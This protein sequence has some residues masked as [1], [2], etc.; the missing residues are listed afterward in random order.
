MQCQHREYQAKHWLQNKKGRLAPVRQQL[1]HH[2]TPLSC[3]GA[4]ANTDKAQCCDGCDSGGGTKGGDSQQPGSDLWQQ[5]SFDN[6][7]SIE[8]QQA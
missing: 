5:V 8:T 6:V 1:S 2:H 3:G 4:D 7:H